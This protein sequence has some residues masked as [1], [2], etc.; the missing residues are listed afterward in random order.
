LP[1]TPK[2]ALLQAD[3]D[4][5]T[6]PLAEWKEEPKQRPPRVGGGSSR[7]DAWYPS[8]KENRSSAE[9]GE[10]RITAEVVP[11]AG[12]VAGKRKEMEAVDGPETDAKAWGAPM[13]STYSGF[14]RDEA[15]GD[16]PGVATGASRHAAGR[17]GAFVAEDDCDGLLIQ[18]RGGGGS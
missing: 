15:R 2:I 14:Y 4:E 10:K 16:V 9:T 1:P 7:P 3:G 6:L 18:G 11:S 8:S 5:W 17:W 13:L 12:R